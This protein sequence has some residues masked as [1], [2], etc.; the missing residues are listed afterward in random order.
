MRM[1]LWGINQYLDLFNGIY[2]P[3]ELNK[4]ILVNTIMEKG[5]D[6]YPYYQVPDRLRD[7]IQGWFYK[8]HDDFESIIRALKADYNPIENYDR[9]ETL[10]EKRVADGKDVLTME[11]GVTETHARSGEEDTNIS[12]TGTNTSNSNGN[13]SNSDV[14][15]GNDR[16]QQG[17]AGFNSSNYENSDNSETIYGGTLNSTKTDESSNVTNTENKDNSKN[18][19]TENNTFSKS[20]SDKDTTLYGKKE[21]IDNTNHI[22]G[23]IGVTTAQ[24]MIDA[25]IQLRIKYEVYEIIY[26][27]F[28]KEFLIQVY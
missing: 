10:S 8:R 11:K 16:T 7:N 21:N 5:G 19:F 22:H 4:S 18:T 1:T 23:N 6:L 15:G 12:S 2:I 27:L 26:Q 13:S 20:G 14:H 24:Q 3:D 28:E 9:Y 17:I 25:E